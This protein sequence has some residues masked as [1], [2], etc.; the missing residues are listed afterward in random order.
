M[1]PANVKYVIEH[2]PEIDPAVV[3]IAPNSYDIPSEISV[4]Y[5]VTD[6]I[7]QNMDCL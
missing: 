6:H 5:G 3:E 7:R 1:S 2:N 4:E